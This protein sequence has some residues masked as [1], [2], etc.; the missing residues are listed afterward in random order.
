MQWHLFCM[1]QDKRESSDF[2][3]SLWNEHMPKDWYKTDDLEALRGGPYTDHYIGWCGNCAITVGTL[4][5]NGR[6]VKESDVPLQK[7]EKIHSSTSFTASAAIHGVGIGLSQI[8]PR[9]SPARTPFE[10]RERSF[11]HWFTGSMSEQ[12]L[13][14]SPSRLVRQAQP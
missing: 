9:A 11:T 4:M 7:T 10:D 13:L 12:V 1:D 2:R 6:S 5:Q 8:T 3:R 14:Y